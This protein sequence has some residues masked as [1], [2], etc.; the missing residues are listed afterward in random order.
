MSDNWGSSVDASSSGKRVG[1]ASRVDV[2]YRGILQAMR[3]KALPNERLPS[4]Q[5][6]ARDFG[7]S[8]PIVRQALAKLRVEGLI[9][10]RRGS[11]SYVLRRP[12]AGAPK[13]AVPVNSIA[14]IQ[15]CFAF[16]LA[17][18]PAC[19]G[20]AAEA[21]EVRNLGELAGC[22]EQME[23]ACEAGDRG[24]FVRADLS[25]HLAVARAAHNVF[26]L[27]AIEQ[28]VHPL[29][30]GMQIAAELTRGRG[31]RLCEVVQSEHKA[32]FTAIEH[33]AAM[34]AA[35]SMRLH[36]GN[37]RRRLFDGFGSV[38]NAI[39]GGSSTVLSE[40]AGR[41]ASEQN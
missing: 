8:R 7:V 23:R 34:D 24:G 19:A 39:P 9:A 25:F 22:I 3:D 14:D 29:R 4:E 28:S 33:G 6:L 10:S 26:L 20:L 16:R 21:R 40:R 38:G 37:A 13:T 27:S 11:G 30:V 35:E 17:V 31:D 2:V 1:S 36:L 32:I 5:E 41:I 18:E 12:E 15:A